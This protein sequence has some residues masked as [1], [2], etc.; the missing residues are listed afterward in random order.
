MSVDTL[1]TLVSWGGAIA[2]LIAI[3]MAFANLDGWK[4]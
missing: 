1:F 2:V 4:D 3:G